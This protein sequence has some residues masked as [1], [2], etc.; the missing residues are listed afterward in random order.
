MSKDE[1]DGDRS[2]ILRW[3]KEGGGKSKILG[4][5]TLTM[6]LGITTVFLSQEKSVGLGIE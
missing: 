3:R 1:G 6:Q 5:T 2:L 4:K